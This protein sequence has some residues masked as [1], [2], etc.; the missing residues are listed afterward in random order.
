[1]I[2]GCAHDTVNVGGW[3]RVEGLECVGVIVQPIRPSSGGGYRG[4]GGGMGCEC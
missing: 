2:R 1:M 4:I 3:C